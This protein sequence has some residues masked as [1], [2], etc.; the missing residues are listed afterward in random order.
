MDWQLIATLIGIGILFIFNIV[1]WF[2]SYNRYSRNE[3][4]H[5]GRL[6]GKVDSLCER[7]ESLEER[8]GRLEQRLTD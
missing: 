6:E 5:L 8:I 4:R 3:A 7:M 1:G 2:I